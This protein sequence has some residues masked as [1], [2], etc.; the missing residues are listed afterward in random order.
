MPDQ[1][2]KGLGVKSWVPQ[3]F[4][5]IIARLVP[6]GVIIGALALAAAGPEKSGA[7]VEQWLNKPSDSYP[8]IAVIIVSG[9]V[10]SYTLAIILLG[11]CYLTLPLA[12][13]LRMM[14]PTDP[15]DDFAMKY[16]YIKRHDPV[17][18]SRITKLKAEMHMAGILIFGLSLSTVIN[19]WKMSLSFNSSRVVFMIVVLVAIAGSAGAFRHFVE[20]QNHAVTNCASLLGY[21]EW[22]QSCEDIRSVAPNH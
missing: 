14:K 17:A 9:F 21:K 12:H 7:F 16:D 2:E 22:K 1:D 10:L 13:R 18:G 4:Y 5:D 20:R 3:L 8:S 15:N 19:F 11:L 6:G